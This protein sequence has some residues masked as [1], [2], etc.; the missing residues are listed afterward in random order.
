MIKPSLSER[1]IYVLND[2]QDLI[3]LSK[4]KA[5]EKKELT[6]TDKDSIKLIRTQLKQDWRTPLISYLN[7]MSKGYKT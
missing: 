3:I 1:R 2:P 7:K 5:L 6:P 4:I